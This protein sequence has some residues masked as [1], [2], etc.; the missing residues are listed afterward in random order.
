[1]PDRFGPLFLVAFYLA[2][3]CLWSCEWVSEWISTAKPT[4]SQLLLDSHTV[5]YLP[6]WGNVILAS[7]QSGL[8]GWPPS[9]PL[10]FVAFIIIIVVSNFFFTFSFTRT[11]FKL[12]T[13]TTF[14]DMESTTQ[15]WQ[16]IFLLMSLW[17]K[18][19]D[20]TQEI[21][22]LTFM[23]FSPSHFLVVCGFTG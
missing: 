15:T 1:M 10:F 5:S 20:N 23:C 18:W 9:L 17:Q 12:Q 3:R 22:S 6:V 19:L 7:Q 4:I 8:F 13:P 2:S 16:C 11:S 14:S 21:I